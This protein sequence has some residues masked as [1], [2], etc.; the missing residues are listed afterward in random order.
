[1]LRTN[2]SNTSYSCRSANVFPL[3][4]SD[5][6]HLVSPDHRL[7]HPPLF[8]MSKATQPD[9]FLGLGSAV[10]PN[11][12]AEFFPIR[13]GIPP[14]FLLL[15]IAQMGIGNGQPQ[16]PDA[17][18]VFVEKLLAQFLVG[19]DPD[20]VVDHPLSGWSYLYRSEEEEKGF[21]PAI[22]CL[23]QHLPLPFC[24]PGQ[25]ENDIFPVLH[26]ETLLG[27]DP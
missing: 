14:L 20:P 24:S 21:P 8:F 26:V 3:L 2:T 25:G 12:L 10:V 1:F 15:V 22:D 9:A 11:D 13:L 5:R 4:C 16:R 27:T 23:L 19:L 18:N 17:G 6:L 7:P